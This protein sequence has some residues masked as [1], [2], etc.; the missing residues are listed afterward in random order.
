MQRLGTW[1]HLMSALVPLLRH[2]PDHEGLKKASDHTVDMILHKHYDAKRKVGWENLPFDLQPPADQREGGSVSAWHALQGC[3]LVMDE[4]LRRGDRAMFREGHA[5]GQTYLPSLLTR[6]QSNGIGRYSDDLL[7]YALV[8]LEH[9]A[10][11]EAEDAFTK[12][13]N[14][15]FEQRKWDRRDLYHHPRRLFYAHEILKRIV[16]RG[17]ERSDFLA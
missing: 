7:L 10:D 1:V 12:T 13:L 17:G 3:W 2:R 8:V 14:L 9:T 6:T 15:G 16:E 5:M 11:A 4:G